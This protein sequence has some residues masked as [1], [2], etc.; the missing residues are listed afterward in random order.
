[1]TRTQDSGYRRFR[2]GWFAFLAVAFLAIVAVHDYRAWHRPPPAPAPDQAVLELFPGAARVERAGEVL[3]AKDAAGLVVGAAFQSARVPPTVKGY[4]GEIDALVGLAPDGRIVQV[5]VLSHRETPY[6]FAMLDGER[7]PT[8]F[9]GRTPDEAAGLDAISG[10][11]VSSE[12]LR[13]DVVLGAAAVARQ[14]WG[15]EPSA[16]VKALGGLPIKRR[17]LALAAGIVALTLAAHLGRRKARWLRV[18][19]WVAS[20][21]VVGIWLNVPVSIGDLLR[22]VAL[23]PPRVPA[24]VILIA[25]AVATTPF[26]GRIYCG[27]ACPFGALQEAIHRVPTRKWRATGAVA[28]ALADLRYLLVVALA[29]LVLLRGWRAFGSFEPYATLFSLSGGALV[30]LYAG[31]AL[32]GS[33]FVKRFWCRFLCPTGACLEVLASLRRA[34]EYRFD[35]EEEG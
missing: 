1:M 4:N 3:W 26:L 5:R 15:I 30:W 14:A 31:L 33:A 18:P 19:A 9:E 29:A 21:A 2:R 8:K 6:Y 17:D 34:R 16:K 35:D 13:N 24:L 27:Y 22:V 25:F 10:A 11:T 7:F 20:V 12:A 28:L 32:T 23:D